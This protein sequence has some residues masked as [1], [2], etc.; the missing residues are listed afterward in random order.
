M[1]SSEP[2]DS[3]FRTQFWRADQPVWFHHLLGNEH[4]RR[5]GSLL[6]DQFHM[7]SGGNQHSH[8]RFILFQRPA[9]DE[10]SRSLLPPPL[11]MTR[12]EPVHYPVLKR[13][14]RDLQNAL[15]L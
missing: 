13:S 10:L 1:L 15:Y 8:Q 3:K 12:K 9:V 2:D 5:G 6:S 7:D 11:A 14:V 4:S